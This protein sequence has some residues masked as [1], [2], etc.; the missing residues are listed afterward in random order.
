MKYIYEN[1]VNSYINYIWHW[2]IFSTFSKSMHPISL[3]LMSHPKWLL[4]GLLPYVVA[5]PALSATSKCN[6]FWWFLV[7][8]FSLSVLDLAIVLL[9]FGVRWSGQPRVVFSF[10][11]LRPA[12]LSGKSINCASEARVATDVGVDMDMDVAEHLSNDI[13]SRVDIWPNRADT[14]RA[15]IWQKNAGIWTL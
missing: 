2:C 14:F 13:W 5:I 12:L 15:S 8:G 11:P 4:S 10:S 6:A 1:F 9:C 3:S 7:F